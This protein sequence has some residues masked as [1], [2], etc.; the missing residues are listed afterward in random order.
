MEWNELTKGLLAE[1]YK[2]E[3]T[4]PGMDAYR[5]HEGGWTYNWKTLHTLVF[6]T[7]CG[8]LVGGS[9][10][11]NGYMSYQGVDWR[12]ENN[13]PVVC[14][15]RFDL[16]FCHMRHPL[17]WSNCTAARDGERIRQCA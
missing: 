17:L 16:D 13:N 6:E 7:P 8:L 14:C 4:P 1:G 15:P 11:S 9:H 3:D 10:F 12:A 5:E 2:P